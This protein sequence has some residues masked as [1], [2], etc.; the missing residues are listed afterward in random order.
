MS[1]AD[2]GTWASTTEPTDGH[3]RVHVKLMS[4]FR[5]H[6]PPEARGEADIALPDGATLNDLVEQLDIHK[7]VKLF[8]VNGEQEK[9]LD[10]ALHDGDSVR[11]YPFVVGG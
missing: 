8:A 6:L 1:E 9:D 10:R 11:I 5:T 4:R 7:R 3:V 2:Q